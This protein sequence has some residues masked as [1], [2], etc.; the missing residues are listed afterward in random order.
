VNPGS[1]ACPAVIPDL[2]LTV[3]TLALLALLVGGGVLFWLWLTRAQREERGF[4]DIRSTL[5]L[6]GAALA[7]AFGIGI[8]SLLPEDPLLTW[9]GIPVE[10]VALLVLLPLLYLAGQVLSARDARRFVIGIGAAV[11]AWFVLWYPNLSALPLPS[12]VVNAYQGFLPTYLYAFQFPVNTAA[13]PATP[14][15]SPIPI[16]LTL[17]LGLTC[18][19]VAYSA[20]VWRLALAESRANAGSGRSGPGGA[21]ASSSEVDG[22]ARTGGGA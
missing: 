5:P 18:L 10:P 21:G 9:R 6:L 16:A 15:I 19:V 2:V 8:A 22:L 17:A 11:T 12:T 14:L 13:R 3:R 4:G 20:S 1:Q 7:V